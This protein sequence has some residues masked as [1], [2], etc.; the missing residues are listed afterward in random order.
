MRG[1]LSKFIHRK[2]RRFC[3]SLVRTYREISSASVDELWQKVVDI[4][5]VS[6]HPMLKSTNVPYGLVPKPGLIYQAVTRLSPIP[7]RIF[8]ERVNPRELLTV[9]VLAIPGVEERITYRV[10]S[11][12]CGTCV[13]YS[14][15]LRGWLSPLIWSFSRPYADRVAR[16]LVEAVEGA[17]LQAVSGKRKSLKDSCFDF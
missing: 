5:D 2:R 12:V 13:S 11:T 15:T 6:W 4:A 14:V 3:A 1:W 7:I 8:V 16:S 9:R 17:T 10:E